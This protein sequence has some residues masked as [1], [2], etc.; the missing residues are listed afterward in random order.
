MEL[1]LAIMA[2]CLSECNMPRP[3]KFNATPVYILQQEYRQLVSKS[4][5]ASSLSKSEIIDSFSG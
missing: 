5:I 3:A 4:T 1:S 2:K